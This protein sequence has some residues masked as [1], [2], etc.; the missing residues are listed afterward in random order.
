MLLVCYRLSAID[1]DNK[2]QLHFSSRNASIK[3]K[4]GWAQCLTS[5]ILATWEM[6]IRRIMV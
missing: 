4:E 1:R 6:E 3:N 2:T 5:V